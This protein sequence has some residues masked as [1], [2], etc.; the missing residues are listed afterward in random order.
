MTTMMNQQPCKPVNLLSEYRDT[1]E[2][3]VKAR[4]CI[5]AV[6]H[7]ATQQSFSW[8]EA[9]SSYTEFECVLLDPVTQLYSESLTKLMSESDEERF[10][11]AYEL[12]LEQLSNH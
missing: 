11:L 7:Y 2:G 12:M 6:V 4:K 8:R 10:L 5:V 1:F 3:T 9:D